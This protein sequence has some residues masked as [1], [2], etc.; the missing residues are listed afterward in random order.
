MRILVV[1]DEAVVARRLVRLLGRVLGERAADVEVALE[2][3]RA[4]EAIR[5]RR[6][7]LLFLDL[8]LE[9]KD[10]FA[11][12]EEAAA[13]SFPA[14]V[15]SAHAEQAARAFEYGVADF[16]V[17]PYDEARLRRAIEGLGGR[18]P[19]R[20]GLRFL[21]IRR[22]GGVELVP[23]ESVVAIRGADDYSEISTRTGARHLHDKTLTALARLLPPFFERVHRSWIVNLDDAASL[24]ARSGSRYF[25]RLRNGD[26][27]PVSRDRVGGLRERML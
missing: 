24:H 1:E 27:V 5:L 26:E 21:A 6:P 12:L 9:G 14:I 16:V 22:A 11:L 25:L 13:S 8:N 18:S 17:K 15:V 3:E 23:I 19:R 20:T 2:L 4:R 10:G 7:D